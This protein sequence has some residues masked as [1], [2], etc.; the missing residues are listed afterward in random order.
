M[1]IIFMLIYYYSCSLDDDFD[2]D[3]Y[4]RYRE[5]AHE[6]PLHLKA[7]H[8]VLES[9]KMNTPFACMCVFVPEQFLALVQLRL[10]LHFLICSI[11]SVVDI[12]SDRIRVYSVELMEFWKCV[13]CGN[14]GDDVL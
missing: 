5:K 7:Q 11:T 2:I 3:H 10:V 4:V 8:M 9:I 13:A 14:H 1:N 12:L 6:S